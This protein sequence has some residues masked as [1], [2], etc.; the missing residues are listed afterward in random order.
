MNDSRILRSLRPRPNLW[1]IKE[2]SGNSF[3]HCFDCAAATK[4]D[5]RTAGGVYFQWHHAKV[6]F[7]GKQQRAAAAR[8]VVDSAVWLTAEKFSPGSG[9]FFQ[10]RAIWS[11]ADNQQPATQTLA[12][13]NRQIDSLVRNQSRQHEIVIV[14]IVRQ[15]EIGRRRSAAE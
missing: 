10:S 6:F 7:A 12:G 13:F 1:F 8:V 5:H 3:D 15:A 14:N 11:I 2:D 9:E 4:R